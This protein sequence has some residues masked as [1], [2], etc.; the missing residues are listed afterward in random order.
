MSEIVLVEKEGP[1][2]LITLNR[3]EKLNALDYAL[4]DRLME[5]LDAIEDDDDTRV[6]VLTGAGTRAFSSGYCVFCGKRAT[7][8]SSRLAIVRTPRAK[9]DRKDRDIPK[10]DHRRG[11]RA[12]PW[13][14]L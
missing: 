6:L 2:A 5:V 9:A 14:R 1:L 10:A 11:Q 4:I 8:P 12:R 3:P 7:R 13:R